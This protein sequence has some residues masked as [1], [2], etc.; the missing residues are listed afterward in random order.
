M[1]QPHTFAS[2][3]NQHTSQSLQK[4]VP[5]QQHR[6]RAK[7][8]RQTT[9]VRSTVG[10]STYPKSG[11]SFSKDSFLVNHPPWRISNQVFW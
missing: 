9:K 10:N 8:D 5:A 2:P 6:Q 3:S 11:V 1:Q 7:W 4:S